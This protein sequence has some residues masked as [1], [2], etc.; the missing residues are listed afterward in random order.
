MCS[1]SGTRRCSHPI[2]LWQAFSRRLPY[3]LETLWKL[4]GLPGRLS[5]LLGRSLCSLGRSLKLPRG[6]S[7]IRRSSTFLSGVRRLSHSGIRG[8]YSG[9]RRLSCS[10]I[11]RPS[12]AGILKQTPT[13]TS[14]PWTSHGG[15]PRWHR[16]RQIWE[17]NRKPSH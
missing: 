17:A 13:T 8:P 3:T 1:S 16:H 4:S 5:G 2:P 15:I 11:R 12:S 7:G 14:C 9:I 10:G 6:Y